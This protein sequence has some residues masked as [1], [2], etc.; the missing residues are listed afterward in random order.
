MQEYD[1][2]QASYEKN[3]DIF[4][5]KR[6]EMKSDDIPA[7]PQKNIV[8]E[9]RK[10]EKKSIQVLPEWKVSGVFS[11]HMVLQRERP[12][13][14][15]G[16]SCHIGAAVSAVWGHETVAATVGENGRFELTFQPRK[17]SFTPSQMRISSEYGNDTFDDIL[18]GDVWV[19]GGQSNAELTLGPCLVDTPEIAK[20]LYEHHPF[21][22]FTQTQAYAREPGSA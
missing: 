14:V 22:L 18:I 21:R 11:S 10:V 12:I 2:N 6:K 4:V 5:E 13:T 8:F 19:I 7:I 3:R 16:W 1:A 20:T 17:A 15:W 9:E